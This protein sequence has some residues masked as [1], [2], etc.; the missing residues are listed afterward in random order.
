M[1]RIWTT[2]LALL[3]AILFPILIWVGLFVAIRPQLVRMMRRVGGIALI[4][5][6]AIS[7]PVLIWVGLF[8]ALKEWGQEWQLKRAPSRTIAETLSAAGISI[9]AARFAEETPAEVI[10]APRAIS[11]IHGIFARAGI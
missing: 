4:L 8:V 3:A 9:Q 10:F 11:E 6:A 1:E 2:L 5:L 7:A